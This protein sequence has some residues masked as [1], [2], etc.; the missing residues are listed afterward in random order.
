MVSPGSKGA[1]GVDKDEGQEEKEDDWRDA[2]DVV[3]IKG[4]VGTIEQLSLPRR[5]PTIPTLPQRNPEA[6]PIQYQ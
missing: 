6:N 4:P 2:E 3:C 1:T 5:R